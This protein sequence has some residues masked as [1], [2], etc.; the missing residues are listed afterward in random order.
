[1]RTSTSILLSVLPLLSA[2]YEIHP[3]KINLSSRVSHLK[4]IV[5]R[6]QLPN[7]SV[8]GSAGAG[9]DLTWLKNRQSDWL[10]RFDWEKEQASLNK[11]NHSTVI[12]GNQTV[13]FI[14]QRSSNPNAIPLL[15]THGWPGSF[16]EFNQ[17]I[18]PLSSPS[19]N[20]EQAF[21]VV[22]PSLPGFG[23]SSPA[24][25]GWGVNDTATLFDTLLSDV[26]GYKSYA[27]VGGDWGCAVTW[28]LHNHHTDHVKAVLYTGL[29]PQ[30][31][32][33]LDTLLA[34]PRFANETASL[35]ELDKQRLQNNTIFP[36]TGMGYFIEQTTR[37]ATIGLALYDN[38]VGQLAWIGEKYLEASD[39]QYGVPPSTITNNTILTSISIYYLTRT[40]ET[41]TNIYYQ[42]PNTF[43]N[44]T[45]H[46]TNQ[47]P[48]GFSSYRYEVQYYPEFY[49]AEVGNLVFYSD[50][51]RGGHFSALDNPPAYIKDVQTMMSKWYK[52]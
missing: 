22:V 45:P 18:T 51:A 10:G 47:A 33:S 42:N 12:I 39:P 24:P 37:P 25:A 28:A 7:T 36:T 26:L 3:F 30:L 6:T 13:H 35:S 50:H 49:L 17:V 48:M 4:D 11:F 41:A 2:A 14:H 5:Q 15:L 19:N 43:Q 20:T 38:P 8:L 9:I 23:F 31:A 46:A 32:P 27:A 44:Q 29:I 52:P 16:Y 40:F 1:M 34:D 21:H